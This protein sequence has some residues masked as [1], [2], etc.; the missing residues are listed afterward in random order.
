MERTVQGMQCIARYT[1]TYYYVLFLFFIPNTWIQ[2]SEFYVRK[3][4]L[5]FLSISLNMC[6][7]CSKEP[8][9]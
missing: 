3:I 1:T 5:I 2:I 6:L 9:H 7:W 4:M 8:S